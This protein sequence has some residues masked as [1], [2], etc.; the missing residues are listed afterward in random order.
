MNN[1]HANQAMRCL[2]GL[3]AQ[4]FE[5]VAARN[6]G[7]VCQS[8]EVSP[9]DTGDPIPRDVDLYLS[10]GGP[11][12]P[13]EGD[14]TTWAADYGALLDGIIDAQSRGGGDR[15]ALFGVC[16]SFEM[17]VRH[18]HLAAVA[19]RTDRKFGVMPIYTT[20]AGQR[21]PL[22]QAFGDRLFAFEHRSWEAI[23]L[24]EAKLKSLGGALLAQESRD[25]V[26]KGRALLG[27]D[28]APGIE[29]VQFHPEA[30]RAGV[31]NWV[32]RPEQADAFK[33]TYGELTYQAM[34]R[35]LDDPR[36]L[37]R[38]YAL[39]IP[40]W[41]TRMFNAIAPARGYAELT[42]VE[43]TEVRAVSAAPVQG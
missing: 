11:G 7:L 14:G 26:S 3:V 22:L 34:M 17:V 8:L 5:R 2:R 4:F 31:M 37:A 18:F 43:R 24:N 6:P 42:P 29:A 33:A 21:H 40:G 41:L 13:Y 38:T 36:R 23:D 25:G 12:S 39:V 16:Y 10:S 1:G 19:Q 28:V 9:R 30:D 15:R 20:Q 35:T 32:S 27:L